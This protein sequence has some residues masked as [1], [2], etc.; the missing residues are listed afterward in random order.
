MVS[1]QLIQIRR[2]CGRALWLDQG[3]IRYQGPVGETLRQYETAALHGE[4][5]G[6]GQGCFVSWQLQDGSHTLTNPDDPL[7]IR[8][9][10]SLAREITSGHFSVSICDTQGDIIAAWAFEP[11]DFAAGGHV[12]HLRTER[13]PLRPGIY[14]VVFVL[15]ERGNHLTGGRLVERWLAL[16]YLSLDVP[17]MS[18]PLDQWAGVLN[19]PATLA[20]SRMRQIA[21]TYP[22]EHVQP[23]A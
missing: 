5:G 21:S 14:Q 4:T 22:A 20:D 16:P 7:T 13:L 2:L 3:R 11:V 1:H 8:I 6:H 12:V 23:S 10:L 18:H 19:I 17:P 15:F 9:E